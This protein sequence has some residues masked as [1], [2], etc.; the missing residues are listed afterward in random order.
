MNAINQIKSSHY[1][2]G[3]I[4]EL[5]LGFGI[6]HEQVTDLDYPRYWDYRFIKRPLSLTHIGGRM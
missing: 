5:D 1:D 4:R 6:F 2:V 3:A